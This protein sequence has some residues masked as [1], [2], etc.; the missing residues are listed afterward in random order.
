MLKNG[1]VIQNQGTIQAGPGVTILTDDPSTVALD[2]PTQVT[3]VS[4]PD[5]STMT[6]SVIGAQ[7][8]KKVAPGT[9][10]TYVIDISNTGSEDALNVLVTDVVDQNLDTVTPLD[11]GTYDAATRTVTWTIPVIKVGLKATVRF[12]ARVKPDAKNNVKIA[13]QAFAEIPG[14]PG[15]VPSDDPDTPAQDD[16]TVLTVEALAS[17]TDFTKA[18]KDVNG[19]DVEPG[20]TLEYTLVVH[21]SG[22]AY[23]FNVVVT[24]VVQTTDLDSLLVGQGGQLAGNTS[25][26]SISHRLPPFWLWYLSLSALLELLHGIGCIQV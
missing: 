5:L 24:D 1:T 18:V 19:G 9:I 4:K 14:Q 11:G 2:D 17:L 7:P 15:N 26:L 13:N 22:T 8:G 6:K 16:P 3:V 25:W 23:A 12:T 10:L 21:N 20:D